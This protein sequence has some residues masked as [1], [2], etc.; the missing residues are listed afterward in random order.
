MPNDGDCDKLPYSVHGSLQRITANIPSNQQKNS[1]YALQSTGRTKSLS[2]SP[3][4]IAM[5]QSYLHP[6]RCNCLWKG[7]SERYIGLDVQDR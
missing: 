6:G 7:I 5:A 2:L 4:Q 3:T 1:Q